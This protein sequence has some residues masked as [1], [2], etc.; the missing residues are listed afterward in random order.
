MSGEGTERLNTYCLYRYFLK[1]DFDIILC[2][3]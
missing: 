3:S 1:V 2:L